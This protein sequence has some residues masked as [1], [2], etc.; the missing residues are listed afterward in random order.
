MPPL[1]DAEVLTWHCHADE[2][3]LFPEGY[4]WDHVGEEDKSRVDVRPID[5]PMTSKI[6][7]A[8]GPVWDL[9]TTAIRKTYTQYEV[10]SICWKGKYGA[11]FHVTTS[12][13][14]S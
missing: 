3:L 2:D 9:I 6:A 5:K 7:P 11:G 4:L 1:L 13:N 14:A 8:S 12:S 10:C